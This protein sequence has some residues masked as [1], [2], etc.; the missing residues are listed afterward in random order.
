MH[1]KKKLFS[2]ELRKNSIY[3]E[4][5]VW[6]KLRNRQY[7]NLKFR[8]KGNRHYDTEPSPFFNS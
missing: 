7:K 6:E 3:E 2:R 1:Y 4:G 5:L 8:L